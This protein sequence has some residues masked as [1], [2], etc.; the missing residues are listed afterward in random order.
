MKRWRQ[1][2]NRLNTE[3]ASVISEADILRGTWNE[4]VSK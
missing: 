3:L 1:D 2:I 4:G